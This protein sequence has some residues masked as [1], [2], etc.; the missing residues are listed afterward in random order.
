MNNYF[1]L[2]RNNHQQGPISPER[3]AENGVTP[4]TLVWCT[5]MADWAPAYT[6]PE[7]KAFFQPGNNSQTPP[8]PN[9]PF[10][11]NDYYSANNTKYNG[12]N[13]PN[14]GFNSQTYQRNEEPYNPYGRYEQPNQA[15]QGMNTNR[16]PSRP[17]SY[18]LWSV[19]VTIFCCLPLGIV[20]IVKAS[21]VD[22]YYMNG[23]Y[24]R[25]FVA[26]ESARS[27]CLISF[28]LGLVTQAGAICW[29]NPF[30]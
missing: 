5:G 8:P 13:N 30:M 10:S 9:G 28:I 7:L 17:N 22:T 12:A 18:L 20:A 25:A 3:F 2:D 16:M 29:F 21:Q 15:Y 11:A 6:V 27:W 23:F 4:N 14:Y 19:L 26:S 1:F 24:D